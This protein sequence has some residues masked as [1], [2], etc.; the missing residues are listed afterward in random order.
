MP[1]AEVTIIP[2]GTGDTSLSD[3]VADCQKVLEEEDIE[4]Q[5]T[6]MG[7]V[8][9]GNLEDIFQVVQKL[10]E[11]PFAGGALRV[12]TTLTIDDRRDKNGTIDQKLNSVREKL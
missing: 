12:S 7:T 2:L 11:V 10:H 8:L 5:L 6:P 3:Y 4:Y 9:E 1:V